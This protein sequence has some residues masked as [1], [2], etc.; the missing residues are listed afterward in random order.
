MLKRAAR[1][2]GKLWPKTPHFEHAHTL[3]GSQSTYA[4]P[5]FSRPA[6]RRI[7]IMKHKRLLGECIAEFLGTMVLIL[8]GSGVVAMTMLFGS[9]VPGEVVRG[10]WTNIT[11]GWGVGVTMGIYVAGRISGA[12]INP[13]V[14]LAMA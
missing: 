13:A 3:R 8:F 5:L 1:P 10:G 2:K 9:G 6:R 4:A 14:T 12:H 7:F 11:L